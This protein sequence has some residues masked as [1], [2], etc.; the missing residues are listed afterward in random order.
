[1]K[2]KILLILFAM[3]VS[4]W[5]HGQEP[6]VSNCEASFTYQQNPTNLM[7]VNF[8][9]TSS[10]EISNY[11]WSFGDGSTFNGASP[12]HAFPKNGEFTVCLTVTNNSTQNPC[13]DSICMKVN[14][15]PYI[16]YDIGGLLFAGT[17]PINNPS[18]T[19]DTA[20]AFLYR[21]DDGGLM[22]VDTVCFDTLGYF[23]FTGV[24]EGSYLLKA[25]LKETSVRFSNYLPSYRGDYLFWV[26]SDTIHVDHDIYNSDIH[27]IPGASISSGTGHIQGTM[28]M[29][30][31]TGGS[32]P[33]KQGQV[34]LADADGNPYVCVYADD[35][36]EFFFAMVPPGEYQI[37]AEYTGSYSQRLD[38]ILDSS[39]S[40]VNNLSLMVYSE[41]PGIHE[42]EGSAPVSVL[43]FPNPAD[44]QVNL[45]LTVD[46]PE[47]LQVQLYNHIGQVVLTTTMQ[48]PAG[49]FQE[50][51]NIQDLPH[52]IYLISFRGIGENWHV[53]KKLLKN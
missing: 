20:L 26:D 17:F 8:T 12:S 40:S 43:V 30:Q 13:I 32:A 33:L 11:F 31:S 38:V 42:D 2:P 7:I 36:G 27:M 34:I 37:F 4:L 53:I 21:L 5:V 45:Q 47:K 10:G 35:S 52:G 28:L 15:Y 49:Q 50:V 25:G 16:S 1:M 29:D 48:L 22:P 6:R 3:S 51:L 46:R 23:W 24:E 19:G 44:G 41:I 39:T 14:V 18:P 9:N